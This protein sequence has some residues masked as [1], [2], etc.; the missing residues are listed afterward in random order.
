[1]KVE[2][3]FSK[4]PAGSLQNL[5]EIFIGSRLLDI[6]LSSGKENIRLDLDTTSALNQEI[7]PQ[8]VRIVLNGY[9][10]FYYSSYTETTA[11][12]R[13]ISDPATILQN[14]LELQ[15][16]IASGPQTL[17]LFC[18]SN[19][20][21]AAGELHLTFTHYKLYDEDYGWMDLTKLVR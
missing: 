9:P 3:S 16:A 10:D 6:V 7:K 19:Q 11:I 20:A 5:L 18:R 15:G 1:M 17:I 8:I 12:R 2:L 21:I 13:R 4:N 14:E